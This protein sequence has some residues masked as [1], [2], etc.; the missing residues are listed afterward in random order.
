[1]ESHQS[2]SLLDCHQKLPAPHQATMDQ[3]A[4]GKGK[5]KV[6]LTG[7]HDAVPEPE[8]E[9]EE[10]SF[11]DSESGS[12]SIEIA[13]LKKRMWKDQLLLM[14]LEG[15][16]RGGGGG[17]GGDGHGQQHR[18]VSAPAK[19]EEPPEARFRRKALLRAQ[20]GVL[21][22]ML[23]MMEACNARGFVYGVVDEHGVPVSGASDSLRGWWQDDVGFDRAGPLAL[24]SAAAAAPASDSPGSPPPPTSF[25]HGLQDIQDS[26]LA[27]LLSA[28]IQHCSPPQRSFP[29][30]RGLPPPWWPTGVSV[31]L[32]LGYLESQV[33]VNYS[34]S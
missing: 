31:N 32:V 18:S 33:C 30:E 22:H 1:M 7:D 11:S 10:N 25:L 3:P 2:L 19:D 27:S 9:Q 20:D 17:G 23:K 4:N 5:G 14:K 13:D 21:R 26:T 6:D 28:L 16:G 34:I 12:E 8:Q 29:L 15:R 24:R